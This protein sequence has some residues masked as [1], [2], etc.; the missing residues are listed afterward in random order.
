VTYGM[1]ISES[2]SAIV[3]GNQRAV[4]MRRSD[5]AEGG[6]SLAGKTLFRSHRHKGQ[7]VATEY[8]MWPKPTQLL[9]RHALILKLQAAANLWR[10]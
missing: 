5:F 10:S 7:R 4:G 6:V 8:T 1:K 3:S 2:E 9:L